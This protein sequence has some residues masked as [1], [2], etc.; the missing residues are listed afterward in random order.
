MSIPSYISQ[1][2]LEDIY[3][4]GPVR[5]MFCNSGTDVIGPRLSTCCRIASRAAESHLLKAWSEAQILE[6]VR[7]DDMVRAAMCD[8]AMNEGEKGHPE[9][10]SGDADTAHEKS[11]KAAEK[12]LESLATSELR[13]RS[14]SA[15][16]GVNPHTRAGL[17][18][19]TDFLF[20]P[21]GGVAK[22][23]F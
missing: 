23:G 2:D 21:S 16:A 6:M 22:T 13:S 7:L 14:E 1:S 20:A 19:T 8:I 9:W 10:R 17:V 12:R 15:G 3:G 11:A 18:T 4:P 5:R